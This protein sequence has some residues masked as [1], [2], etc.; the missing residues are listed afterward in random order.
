MPSRRL[1]GPGLDPGTRRAWRFLALARFGYALGDV[2]WLLEGLL[3]NRHAPFS[4][5]SFFYLTHSPLVLFG[6]L[7]FPRVAR[8]GREKVQFWLDAAHRV[9]R[10]GH[11]LVLRDG[12]DDG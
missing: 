3:Q 1:D 8:T 7:S 2:F 5:A 12:A 6:L 9:P 11:G 4:I 10:R